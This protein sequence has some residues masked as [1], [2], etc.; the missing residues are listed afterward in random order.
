M[1]LKSHVVVV[2]V[3]I[4]FVA[5]GCVLGLGELALAQ[6]PVKA[7]EP[8][9][10]P[11]SGQTYTGTKACA[12]CHFDQFMKWK[13]S[14]HAKSFELLPAKYQSDAKC[15][16]CHTVGFGQATGFKDA[17]T[18]VD[19]KGTGCEACHGPGSKHGEIAKQFANKKL[20]PEQEKQVRD[21]IWKIEPTNACAACHLV[22]GHHD[23]VTPPELRKKK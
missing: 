22:Q 11:P 4:L 15:L 6:P 8:E 23:S 3:G 9:P 2:K 1:M 21:S 10:A 5:V 20:T 12:A 14:A 18:S 13:A 16:P 7:T 19:L 17:K